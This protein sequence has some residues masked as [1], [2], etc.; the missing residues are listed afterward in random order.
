[1][2]KENF[3]PRKVFSRIG[4]AL[5]L[6]AAVSSLLQVFC[7]FVIGMLDSAGYSITEESWL[8]WLLTFLPIYAVG[9]PLGLL[10]LQKLPVPEYTSNKLGG[11]NFF[12]LLLIGIFFMYVGNLIGNVLSYL[13]SSGTA[14]NAINN[15]IFDSS[16]L[17]I[18]V[19]VVLAPLL[20]EFV[21]RKQ[22]I[23]R[24]GRYGEKTA[25]L[26]S[27]LTFALFHMNLYQMFYAFGLGLVFAYVYTRTHRLRYP[28]IMHMI[29]N[30]MGSVLAPWI[31]SQINLETLSDPAA[32][33][34]MSEQ[35]AMEILPGL[36]LFM[37]YVMLL[38]GLTIAGLVLFILKVRKLKFLPAA[39]ELPKGQRFK[40]AYC[41]WW[42]L[43][44]A[45]FCL[46]VCAY[47][48][49]I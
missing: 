20:E 44:F 5:F 37:F 15:Y 43:L 19:I 3:T 8:D 24:C 34:N 28:V 22:I 27:A 29:I 6:I 16:P 7:F 45:A 1:M 4:L 39:E 17:K 38:L 31:I 42:M 36:L 14:Q 30:F 25:I 40:T 32:L 26:L 2:I 12:V 11:K 33:M 35:A 41:N 23:D 21:F 10:V 48:L 18:I 49:L 9:V 13:L 46:S 47:A